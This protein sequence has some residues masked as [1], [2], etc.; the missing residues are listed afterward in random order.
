MNQTHEQKENGVVN[1][2]R[3]GAWWLWQV[4]TYVCLPGSGCDVFSG[5]MMGAEDLDL[6]L[7]FKGR[8]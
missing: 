4:L 7:C 8:L 6:E 3:C 2:L 1:R 5:T